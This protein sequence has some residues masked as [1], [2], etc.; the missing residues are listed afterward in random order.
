MQRQQR[1]GQMREQE[2]SRTMKKVGEKMIGL[3]GGE[4]EKIGQEVEGRNGKRR[5]GTGED[6]TR[7]RYDQE[8]S[9]AG[10]IGM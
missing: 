9:G 5:G 4:T 3:M 10:R 6:R 7:R 8:N 2:K 1:P